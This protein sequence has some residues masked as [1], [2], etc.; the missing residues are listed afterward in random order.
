[1][2]IGR[3]KFFNPKGRWGIITPDGVKPKERDKQVF[4]YEN[5]LP[6]GMTRIADG[7]EVEYELIPNHPSGKR[8]MSIKILGH[9]YAAD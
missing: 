9:S 4:F 5:V 8:A 2:S 7:A 6:E 1:V 3:V